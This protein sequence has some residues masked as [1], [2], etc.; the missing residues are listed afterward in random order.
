MRSRL[1]P[2]VDVQNLKDLETF[3]VKDIGPLDPVATFD[4]ILK[5]SSPGSAI[6]CTVLTVQGDGVTAFASCFGMLGD[7]GTPQWPGGWHKL[8][9]FVS[10]EGETPHVAGFE[11]TLTRYF[12]D[13]ID[14]EA[15]PDRGVL[16]YPFTRSATDVIHVTLARATPGGLTFGF[17]SWNADNTWGFSFEP[18]ML[19]LMWWGIGPALNRDSAHSVWLV[20]ISAPA[21]QHPSG[22]TRKWPPPMLK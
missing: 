11:G 7:Y 3:S 4:E 12:S 16:G 2:F 14:E 22:R 6:D 19:D 17:S 9:F 21:S 13:R 1:R 20:A 5:G 18:Q 10:A 8:T 15:T